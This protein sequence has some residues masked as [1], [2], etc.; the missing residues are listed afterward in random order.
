[1]SV[2]L[3]SINSRY[4]CFLLTLNFCEIFD[5]HYFGCAICN[6][7]IL[8][9]RNSGK[10]RLGGGGGEVGAENSVPSVALPKKQQLNF[11]EHYEFNNFYSPF[12]NAYNLAGMLKYINVSLEW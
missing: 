10:W 3:L 1:M 6:I 9:Y 8:L 5:S 4:F 11:M 12:E 2:A 7:L